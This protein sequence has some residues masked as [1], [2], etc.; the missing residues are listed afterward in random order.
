M[1]HT[2][3]EMT[4]LAAA[5]LARGKAYAAEGAKLPTAVLNRDEFSVT[6]SNQALQRKYFNGVT[7]ENLPIEVHETEL[8]PGEAPHLAHTHVHEEMAVVIAGTLEVFI[9]GRG[10]KKLTA[11]GLV[12]VA[13]GELHGWKNTGST[14]ARYLVIAIGHD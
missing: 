7:H 10:T 3:R 11:G 8:P 1:K 2:R 4:V 9:Q 14:P 12:Y 6:K 5:L 13:S